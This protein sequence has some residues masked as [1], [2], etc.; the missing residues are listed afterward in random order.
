MNF[1][2]SDSNFSW[3]SSKKSAIFSKARG[4][5]FSIYSPDLSFFSE[6]S[7]TFSAP[8][9]M[10][11]FNSGYLKNPVPSLTLSFLMSFAT[12]LIAKYLSKMIK[13]LLW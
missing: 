1:S 9:I 12:S 8:F 13:A 3:T 6:S 4:K 2:T 7:S 10:I 5:S 11:E